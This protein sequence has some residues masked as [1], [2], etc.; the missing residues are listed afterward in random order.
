MDHRHTRVDDEVVRL[1]QWH[2]RRSSWMDGPRVMDGWAWPPTRRSLLSSF[3][4]SPNPVSK[5]TRWLPPSCWHPFHPHRFNPSAATHP[6]PTITTD[7]TT[8]NNPRSHPSLPR[9]CDASVWCEK[10]GSQDTPGFFSTMQREDNPCAQRQTS[11]GT[12]ENVDGKCELYAFTRLSVKPSVKLL[13]PK[14]AANRNQAA[15]HITSSRIDLHVAFLQMM[16]RRSIVQIRTLMQRSTLGLCA[17]LSKLLLVMVK[18]HE[19]ATVNLCEL[20]TRET[21]VSTVDGRYA[22]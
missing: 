17:L 8:C 19:K 7:R 9:R 2:K 4:S 5:G 6:F 11:R 10:G 18:Y 22:R 1:L 13:R 14:D 20:K 15:I 3:C 16:G 21:F 12:P